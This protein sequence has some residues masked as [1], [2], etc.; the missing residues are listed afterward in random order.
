MGGDFVRS[1][2]DPLRNAY[3]VRAPPNQ[4]NVSLS[5]Y[6][7]PSHDSHCIRHEPIRPNRPEY[8]LLTLLP[9]KARESV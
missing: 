4:S 6:G 8:H 1:R 3:A 2:Y 9:A 5:R 7:S